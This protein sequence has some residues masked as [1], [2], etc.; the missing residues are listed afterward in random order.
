MPDRPNIIYFQVDNLGHGELGCYDGGLRRGAVTQRLD[1]FATEGLKLWHFVTEPQCTPS[2]SAL[3]TGRHPIRSGTHTVALGGD[4]G[5]LVAWERTMGDIL[6]EAGYATCCVGK[7]HIGAEAGRW[8]TDHGFDEFYGIPR[9]YDECLW[10]EDPRYDP[11]RDLAVYTVEGTKATGTHERKDEQLTL[12]LRRNTDREYERR[13]FDFLRRTVRAGQPFFLYYNHSMMHL[14][15]IPRDEFKG[16][17]GY[18]DWQDC[19]LEMDT[20]FGSLLDLLDELEVAANTIVVF[21]GDNGPEEMLLHRGVGGLYEG[22]YFTASEGGLRSPCLIRW[23]GTIPAG[24]ESNEM[25]HIS[26][27]FTTLLT[28]V[29][30][31]VP[32]DR[33]I[34]GK[35]HTAF[36]KGETDTSA[37]DGVII[38][39]GAQ[40]H[41]VKWK[42]Y[43][44]QLVQSRYFFD[45]TL[46]L[47][48]PRIIDL[49]TDP[50][51]RESVPHPQYYSTWV[52]AH[53]GRLLNEYRESVTREPLIP[54]GAPLDYVPRAR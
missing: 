20:D 27:M 39:V 13:A 36:F 16:K 25:V 35:D 10:P 15:N 37:R 18:G 46:P 21:A 53:L 34:D 2:R 50:K 9:S 12:E 31:T 8:P 14:P 7:W 30:C 22:S 6:S 23:P 54:A 49:I 26:D 43:K 11:R 38:W 41:G 48:N 19:L 28:L 45:P 1:R 29:G 32:T 33:V 4:E 24:R 3:M 40:M 52:L 51:E 44:L 17:S 47:G 42:D 5:G